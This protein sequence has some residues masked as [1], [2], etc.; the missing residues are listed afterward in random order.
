MN[1][2][3][4]H[5]TLFIM[6]MIIIIFIILII[7]FLNIFSVDYSKSE[8]GNRLDGIEKVKINKSSTDKLVKEIKEKEEVKDIKYRLQGRLIYIT[9]TYVET[10]ELDR[11]KEIASETLNYFDE[12]E[13]TYYDMN[14]TLKNETEKDGYPK[15]GYKH[16][17]S[18]TIVW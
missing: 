2:I 14:F 11:A 15:L 10:V 8:Y 17:T 9:I 3:K 13:K 18:D 6:G 4:K 16:K 1:F 7:I 5:K 12:E